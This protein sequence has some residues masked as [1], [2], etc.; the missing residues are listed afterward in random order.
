MLVTSVAN[1][2]SSNIAEPQAGS[3]ASAGSFA[4]ALAAAGKNS[5]STSGAASGASA[6]ESSSTSKTQTDHQLLLKQLDD[7]LKK[8]PIAMLREKILKSMGLTEEK[9]Q[10]MPPEQRAKVEEDIAAKIKEYLLAH[11]KEEQHAKAAL[12]I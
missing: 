7:Y 1:A 9:L 5:A 11:K 3:A 8:G 6:T 2:V 10:K 12:T 4:D